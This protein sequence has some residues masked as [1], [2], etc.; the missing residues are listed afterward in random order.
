LF[1]LH[2]EEIVGFHRPREGQ[3]LRPV[4]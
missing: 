1:P 4:E 2:A 3:R